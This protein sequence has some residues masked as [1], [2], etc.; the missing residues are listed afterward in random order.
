M[1]NRSLVYNTILQMYYWF[2]S[3]FIIA[4][5]DLPIYP[6]H[7]CCWVNYEEEYF[8]IIIIQQL[9]CSASHIFESK[10]MIRMTCYTKS[11]FLTRHFYK[12]CE[13]AQKK[14]DVFYA[15]NRLSD[16]EYTELTALVKA[17]YGCDS[18]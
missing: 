11:K 4:I 12:T 13:I 2:S 17:V 16:D 8:S 15:V 1:K 5:C 9:G 18:V 3:L 14:L 10:N 6:N 7:I